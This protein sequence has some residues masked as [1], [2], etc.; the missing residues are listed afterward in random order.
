METTPVSLDGTPITHFVNRYPHQFEVLVEG[1]RPGV[2]YALIAGQNIGEA[3]SRG[4]SMVRNSLP[5]SITGPL[6][7]CPSVVIMA[8]GTPIPGGDPKNGLREWYSDPAIEAATGIDPT[9]GNLTEPT[10]EPTH[11]PSQPSKAPG[12]ARQAQGREGDARVQ[13]RDPSLGVQQG[14]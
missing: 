5:I 7:T 2:T 6:G 8:L 13:S 10:K 12:T 11:A 3:T 1:G 14:S 9:T 4:F